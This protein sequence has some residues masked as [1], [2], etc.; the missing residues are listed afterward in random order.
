MITS[1]AQLAEAQDA[2]RRLAVVDVELSMRAGA[3]PK[4]RGRREIKRKV[5][6]RKLARLEADI[7]EYTGSP[8]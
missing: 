1:Q 6:L 4:D 7:A 5:I 8:P 3:S 2:A